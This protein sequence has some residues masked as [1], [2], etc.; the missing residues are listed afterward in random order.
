MWAFEPICCD[1]CNHFSW[2][3]FW[4]NPTTSQTEKTKECP[5]GH[6]TRVDRYGACARKQSYVDGLP[7]R[8][9]FCKKREGAPLVTTAWL[10]QMLRYPFENS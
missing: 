6:Y 4:I 5:H 7:G 8:V 9:T 3:Y 1:G 2:D 10:Q